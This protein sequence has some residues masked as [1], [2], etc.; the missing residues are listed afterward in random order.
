MLQSC[1]PARSQTCHRMLIK[2]RPRSETTYRLALEA[3]LSPLLAH[4]IA[5]RLPDLDGDIQRIIKPA[6]KYID[7]PEQL[8]DA[9]RAAERIADAVMQRQRIGILTDYD[10]DGVTSHAVIY[11][12]LTEYFGFPNSLIDSLIGHRIRDGYGI[13]VNLIERILAGNPLPEVIIT[14]DCGSSDEPRI[15][16]LKAAGI[17][18]IVTDHHA[19]SIEGPPPSAYAVVNPTRAD[20][21]YPDDTIAGC[22]AAWLLMSYVRGKLIERGYLPPTTPKLSRELDYVSLGTVTDCVSIG[23]AI[24]R[25]VVTIGLKQLN[26][27]ER[28]CWRVIRLLLGRQGQDFREEDLAFQIGPRI[29]ARSRLDDP[30]AALR[31]LLADTDAEARRY[32]A[33]L[34]LDN[35]DR[36]VIERDMLETA[37]RQAEEQIGQGRL[38][39]V[40][41]LEDGH[42]GVQG[43]VASRLVDAFGRPAIVL[44]NTAEPLHL[45]GSARSIRE[46]H[47]RNA[48]QQVA[49]A[50]PE[51]FVKFGGHCGAAGLTIQRQLLT[52]FQDAFEQAVRAEL[53]AQTLA[54]TIW[55]D[56]PLP[57]QALTLETLREL[58]QLQP[59]GREFE[60]PLFEGRFYVDSVRVVGAEPIH[61]MLILK[62]EDKTYDAV[63]FRA[64]E[65]AGDP[66]PVAVGEMIRCAY[67][68]SSREYRGERNLRLMIGYAGRE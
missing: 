44:C 67:R 51:L 22:M 34:D 16:R 57:E 35:Q 32:L 37:R 59:Y 19:L 27:F 13:S 21:S 63:W 36:K 55:T 9:D 30:Y 60:P 49:D 54:P 3:G 43:I 25:A 52:V 53:G 1:T 24:N 65:K 6:L 39:L 11:Q 10:V 66:P 17:D 64:L 14:A 68:L 40:V 26:R 33:L 5:G 46:L 38:S 28:P 15:A 18:V 4:I 23:T 42:A 47:L 8:K 41:Y 29:N 12:A 20:C 2:Q 45:T 7:H 48:L 56:G 31:Y 58:D 62:T 50:Q 61:L